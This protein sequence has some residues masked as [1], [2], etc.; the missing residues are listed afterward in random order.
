MVGSG[1]GRGGIPTG[2][3]M[4]IGWV[5]LGSQWFEVGWMGVSACLG[6][7]WCGGC[8]WL[9]DQWVGRVCLIGIGWLVFICLVG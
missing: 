6:D 4:L 5:C 7:Q 1:G 3:C 2:A 8:V 9:G